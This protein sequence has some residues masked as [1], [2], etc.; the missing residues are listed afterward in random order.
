MQ[1]TE[2]PESRSRQPQMSRL[3][4]VT[5]YLP[6]S[7]QSQPPRSNAEADSVSNPASTP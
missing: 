2:I 3:T 7:R 6:D 5:A 1:D 4:P